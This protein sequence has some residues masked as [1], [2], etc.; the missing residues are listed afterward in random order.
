VMVVMAAF[1]MALSWASGIPAPTAVLATA[2]GGIAEMSLTAKVLQFGVPL[3]TVF[4][5]SRVLALVIAIGPLYA[6]MRP[7][8]EREPQRPAGA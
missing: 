8:L 5:V 4:H 2:P 1:G 3:V 6:A 7:W